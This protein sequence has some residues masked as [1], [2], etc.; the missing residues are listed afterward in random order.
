LEVKQKKID[1]KKGKRTGRNGPSKTHARV[2]VKRG[3]SKKID[4]N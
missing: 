3:N 2:R 4:E 1:E